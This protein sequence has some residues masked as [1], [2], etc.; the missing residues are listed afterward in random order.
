MALDGQIKLD[1]E[2]GKGTWITTTALV[3]PDLKGTFLLSGQTQ[4][5]L[6]I[7]PQS[8]PKLSMKPCKGKGNTAGTRQYRKNSEK[9]K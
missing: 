2:D 9:G 6:G 4:Q 7:L 5:E 8:W 1:I 3:T